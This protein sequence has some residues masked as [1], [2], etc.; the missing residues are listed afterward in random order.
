MS[1]D[2]VEKILIVTSVSLA[3]E[4]ATGESINQVTF[5]YYVQNTPE[6]LSRIPS[7]TRENFMGKQIAF[8]EF[9]LLFKAKEVP[10]KVGSKWKLK[11]HKNGSINVVEAK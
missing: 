5:G 2:F 1:E 7:S 6:I 3:V 4:L 11:I 9:S 8:N 10:Y